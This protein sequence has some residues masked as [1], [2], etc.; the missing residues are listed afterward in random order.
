MKTLIISTLMLVSTIAKADGFVCTVDDFTVRAYDQ[1]QPS[2][3]TK[4]AAVIVI[5]D[6]RVSAGK[7][8][9]A[10]FTAENTATGGGAH[11]EANVDLRYTDSSLAGRLIAG[12]K[13]GFLDTIN[14]DVDYSYAHPMQ[15]SEKTT[16]VLTLNKRNGQVITLD[17]DCE[18]YLKN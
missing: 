9:I 17:V 18:R 4:N 14:L 13:L 5:S 1:V 12:T 11:F 15:A 8:T 3:G 10:R 2:E 6:A 7:K 16:G